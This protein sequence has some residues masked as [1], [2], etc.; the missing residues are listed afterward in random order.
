M[1]KRTFETAIY[2]NVFESA[3]LFVWLAIFWYGKALIER[4]L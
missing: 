2:I 3:C 4:Q 1:T